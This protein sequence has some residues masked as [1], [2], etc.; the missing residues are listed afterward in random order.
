V[1]LAVAALAGLLVI[2]LIETGITDGPK[3]NPLRDSGDNYAGDLALKPHTPAL[4]TGLPPANSSPGTHHDQAATSETRL[5]GASASVPAAEQ[6]PAA[7]E[8]PAPAAVGQARHR[9]I[10]VRYG[11]TLQ[12]LSIRYLGSQKRLQSLIDANPQLQNFNLLYP[13]QTVYLPDSASQE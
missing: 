3:S 10:R 2:I 5:Q 12:R 6:R 9:G 13:G 11:D 1:G 7:R 8:V 4:M